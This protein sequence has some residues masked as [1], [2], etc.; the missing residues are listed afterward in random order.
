M[1]RKRGKMDTMKS[2]QIFE[3]VAR[4]NGVSSAEVIKEIEAAIVSAMA[5]PDPKVQKFWKSVPRKGEQP[6]PAE[7]FTYLCGTYRAGKHRPK[8][9][10]QTA[11]G[12]RR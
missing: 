10:F 3:Q 1:S 6:T 4:E 2:G 11:V 9:S 7:L 12:G 8:F 5:N